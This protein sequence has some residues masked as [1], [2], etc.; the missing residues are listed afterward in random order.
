MRGPPG[1]KGDPIMITVWSSDDDELY[2]LQ[3]KC[4]IYF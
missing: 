4:F 1:P 3:I 2:T